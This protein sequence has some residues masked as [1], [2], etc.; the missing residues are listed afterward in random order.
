MSDRYVALVIGGHGFFGSRLVERLARRPELSIVV[1]GRNV[2][3]AEALVERLRGTSKAELRAA[4]IDIDSP[5]LAADLRRLAPRVVVHTAGPF[6]R[7]DHRV[8]RACIEAGAHYIDLADGRAFVAGIAELDDAA[9]AAGVLVTSGASSVPALSSA[10]AD[11]L[12]RGLVEVHAIDIGISPGNRTERGRSTVEAILGYCGQPLPC[13]GGITTFG[14]SGS[15][16]HRYPAP[17]GQRLLSPCDVPDLMLL[18]A[19]YAGSPRVRFGAG[20]ELALMHRSMNAMAAL[21]RLG[22]VPDWSAHAGWLTRVADALRG[23]G[24]DAGAMHVQVRGLDE[25]GLRVERTWQLVATDGDGP[26]V[27][28]LAAAA[29]VRKLA[30]GTLARTGA[31]PCVGLLALADFEREAQSLRVV[32][33][34]TS[35]TPAPSMYERVMRERYARL[36]PAVQRFHRLAGSKTLCGEVQTDAPGSIIA[37]LLALG[38]GTPRQSGSGPIRFELDATADT[39]RWTRHFPSRTMTSVLRL[40]GG[41]L[42]ERLGAA[43]LRFELVE[44]DGALEM[45]LQ[46]LHFL[47]ITCPRWFMPRIVARE[48]GDGDRLCFEVSAAVPLIGVVARYRGYLTVAERGVVQSGNQ[49]ADITRSKV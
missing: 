47:G 41:Q 27:P 7:Q 4:A 9:T 3:A 36:A 26:S 44:I 42:V 28:T 32:M 13:S 20:L 10:A 21:A 24:T 15:R 29:L 35:T 2:R 40:E 43:R 37:R 38:L 5:S 30:D 18:P 17:V 6:Q 49:S 1:A 48:T 11:R 14:W 12:A 46:R 39:E 31:M 22:L 33:S 23:F 45:K 25:D 16:R 34:E 19:R 8:S